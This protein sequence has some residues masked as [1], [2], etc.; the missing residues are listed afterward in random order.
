MRNRITNKGSNFGIRLL[1]VSLILLISRPGIAQVN[2]GSGVNKFTLTVN[3]DRIIYP[4]HPDFWGTNFLNWVDDDA[5]LANGKIAAYIKEAKVKVL[6]FPGGTVADNY[7]WRT[8]TLENTNMFP[9]ESG[10]AETDFD[11]FMLQC[12]KIGAEASIVLNTE[13]W[14]VKKDFAGG[15]HEAAEWLRYCRGKGYKVKYWEIGNET[16]WHPI[17]SADEYAD[18]INIYADS[19]KRIDPNIILGANGHWNTDFTGTKERLKEGTHAR[20]IEYRNNITNKEGHER[21]KNFVKQST[22]LPITTGTNKWWETVARKSGK[23]IDMIIVHWYFAPNQLPIVTKKLSEVK[24]LFADAYPGKK[25][26]LNI[27]EYNVTERT[28]ESH[29]HLTEM[30]G[31]MLTAGTDITGLW[32]VRL[33]YKKPTLLNYEGDQS[34]NLFQIHKR[35]ASSMTGSLVQTTSSA[36]IPA[37]A[38]YSQESACIVISGSKVDKPSPVVIK[39]NGVPRSFKSCVV[40]RI[41]GTEFNYQ[42]SEEI[43]NVNN[44]ESELI[45]KPSEVIIATFR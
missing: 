37:F 23:N 16:Y 3:A 40:W 17:M 39:L 18:L 14:A 2:P 12:R 1:L 28:P 5:A 44:N 34:S 11:E 10:S 9:Y 8:N 19:L 24:K 30:V 43:V 36:Q 45:V 15:A 21:Y 22:I 41:R 35:L 27:S 33:K 13:T 6:R 31:A 38:S 32:P 42:V 25:F 4:I 7:H 20:V 29:M 26:L